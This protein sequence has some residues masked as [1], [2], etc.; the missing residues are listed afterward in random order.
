[1]V[2]VSPYLIIYQRISYK[3]RRIIIVENINFK[4]LIIKYFF[5]FINR[6]NF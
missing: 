6:L 4:L 3:T 2:G 5:N 1:M